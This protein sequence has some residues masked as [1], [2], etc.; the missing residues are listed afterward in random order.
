MNKTNQ[1]HFENYLIKGDSTEAFIHYY[2]RKKFMRHILSCHIIAL[3]LKK[4]GLM[5]THNFYHRLLQYVIKGMRKDRFERVAKEFAATRLDQYLHMPHL[6]EVI[7]LQSQGIDVIVQS[8]G[9]QEWVK[10]WC[11][12]FNILYVQAC[13]AEC[14]ENGYLTG[15][16]LPPASR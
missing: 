2:C 11:E 1:I 4:L 16:I 8:A 9:M 13:R 3:I 15:K 12:K 5:S 14:D 6:N 7:Q 10:P